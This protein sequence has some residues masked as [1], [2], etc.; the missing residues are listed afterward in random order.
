MKT[1]TK[2]TS[3][4]SLFLAQA[5][6]PNLIA[7][8]MATGWSHESGDHMIKGSGYTSMSR[9]PSPEKESDGAS[10][11]ATSEHFF[12]LAPPL[13]AREEECPPYFDL[14]GVLWNYGQVQSPSSRG[15][16]CSNRVLP[17]RAWR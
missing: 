11:V 7:R 8:G 15:A 3:D 12:L 6:E 4:C 9:R 2:H 14:Q 1:L 13:T 5:V 10:T 17:E 16:C